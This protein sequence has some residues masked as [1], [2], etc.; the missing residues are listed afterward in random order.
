MSHAEFFDASRQTS[1]HIHEPH[2]EI[3]LMLTCYPGKAAETEAEIANRT[4]ARV[5]VKGNN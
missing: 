2:K 5:Q 3:K 4:A 1:Q